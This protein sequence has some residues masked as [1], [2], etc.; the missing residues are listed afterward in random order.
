[1]KEKQQVVYFN[2]YSFCHQSPNDRTAGECKQ[3]D[4][5]FQLLA[6][7]GPFHFL[8]TKP[9]LPQYHNK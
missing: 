8:I 4:K 2:N 3:E 9:S 7:V 1:M 5:H 6:S